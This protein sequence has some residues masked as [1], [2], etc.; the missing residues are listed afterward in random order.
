MDE[1]FANL[2]PD[3]RL[4]MRELIKKIHNEQ[5][6]TVIFVTHDI[7][8]AMGLADRIIVLK[9]GKIEQIGTPRELEEN[10]QAEILKEF[11]GK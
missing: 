8:E 11:F 2:H 9:D 6:I 4:Q 3:L 7:A 1:P 5:R 10:P